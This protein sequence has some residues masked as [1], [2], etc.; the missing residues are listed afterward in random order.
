MELRVDG[1]PEVGA[2]GADR[3]GR[4][5][6]DESDQHLAHPDIL[7]Y[8]GRAQSLSAANSQVARYRYAHRRPVTAAC[9]P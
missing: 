5:R 1:G 4:D 8:Q 9:Q 7:A 6:G 3:E 2:D